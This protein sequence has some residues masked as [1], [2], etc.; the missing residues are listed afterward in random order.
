MSWFNPL[1]W[2][3]EK[4]TKVVMTAQPLSVQVTSKSAVVMKRYAGRLHRLHWLKENGEA[5]PEM[6]VEIEKLGY[7]LAAQGNP[8]PK[9]YKEAELLRKRVGG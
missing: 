1:T 9:S 7:L 3:K 4:E 5:T 2:F 6:L 8:I